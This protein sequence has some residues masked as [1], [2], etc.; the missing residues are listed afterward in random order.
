MR[1]IIV[2]G[3][4]AAGLMAAIKAAEQG[5]SVTLL[6]ANEKPGKKLLATGNGRCNFTNVVQE[7]QYYRGSDPEYAWQI[8]QQFPMQDTLQFF[9]R[10]GIYAR[11]RNGWLLSLIHI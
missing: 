9:S 10:L 5:A 11:N 2:I 8:L 4:G 7:K 6:E 3:G 1:S